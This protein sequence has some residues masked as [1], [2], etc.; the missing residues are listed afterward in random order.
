MARTV[1]PGPSSESSAPSWGLLPQLIENEW[2]DP[3]REH[4]LLVVL[5]PG[6]V[7]EGSVE[8]VAAMA[9]P[10]EPV[11]HLVGEGSFEW[12]RGVGIR[13]AEVDIVQVE[14]AGGLTHPVRVGVDAAGEEGGA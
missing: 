6:P 4:A 14:Q 7:G 3:A 13:L 12:Q 8:I 10:G 9:E 5:D 1:M 11:T 2:V